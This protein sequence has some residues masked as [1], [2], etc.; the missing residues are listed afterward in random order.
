MNSYHV[1]ELVRTH[2]VFRRS[3]NAQEKAATPD[4]T[5]D[6]AGGVGAENDA[7]SSGVLLHRSTE[8]GL[9]VAGEEVGFVDDHDCVAL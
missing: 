1:D 5:D 8:G 7:E 6:A 9:S 3:T 2:L 4:G